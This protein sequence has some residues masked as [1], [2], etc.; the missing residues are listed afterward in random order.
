M[1]TRIYVCVCVGGEGGREGEMGPSLTFLPLLPTG[2]SMNAVD[3]HGNTPLT[4]AALY[5]KSDILDIL[6][7]YGNM[8]TKLIICINCVCVCVLY[9]CMCLCVHHAHRG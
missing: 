4:I 2:L 8:V 6:L 3:R 9:V 1:G 5:G 7:Q